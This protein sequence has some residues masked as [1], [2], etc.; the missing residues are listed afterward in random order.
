MKLQS[1][2]LQGFKS[3]AD[4]TVFDFEHQFTAVVGPNG[5]GKSNIADAIRWVLGEQSMKLLRSKSQVDL[6]FG[7]SKELSRLGMAQVTMHLDNSDKQFPVEYNEVVITRKLFR[8][9]ES[10]Y[11]LNNA[12]VRLQDITM[13]LAQ[14]QFGQKS[15]AV[16]GQGMIT[17]FLNATPQERKIFFDEATGVREFQMKRDQA[18]N[19]LIRS[20][21]NLIQSEAVL[22]E[23]APH[24]A[25]LQRQVDRLQK[26]EAIEKELHLLEKQYYGSSWNLF[27]QEKEELQKKYDIQRKEIHDIEGK[28]QVV[29]DKTDGIA[30]ETSR[31]QRYDMLQQES[32]VLL[33]KKSL[34]LKEQAL[35][36]AKLEI[37]QKKQGDLSLLWIEKKIDEIEQDVQKSH[38]AIEQLQ[39]RL[40]TS[41]TEKERFYSEHEALLS[42]IQEQEKQRQKVREQIEKEM[43]SMTL[44]EVEK[45]I[46]TI[47]YEQEKFLQEL[48]QTESLPAFRALQQEGKKLFKKFALFMDRFSSHNTGPADVLVL[49]SERIQEVITQMM[50]E[51]TRLKEEMNR[52]H[53]DSAMIEKEITLH[54]TQLTRFD[55]ERETLEKEK[56]AALSDRDDTP[57]EKEQAI[58]KELEE[59]QNRILAVDEENKKIRI[60][61]DD[62]HAAEEKKKTE[63]LN[64]QSQM[65][66][67]QRHL[68]TT[69]Q[70]A[71]SIEIQIARVDT[72]LQDMRALIERDVSETLHSAIFSSTETI[73]REELMKVEKQMFS[74]RKQLEAIGTIDA[75]IVT[76]Y[77]ETKERHDFLE[78]QVN[79][80]QK[81][82]HTLGEMIDD[83]DET[84]RLQFSR[85][86]KKINEGFEKYF[87]VLFHG[88]SAT[89]RMRTDE[90]DAESDEEKEE[91]DDAQM[92]SQGEQK[93]RELIG[94]KKK[95]Q[96]VISG[97]EVY[98]SPPQ[99][100]VT[101][102]QSLSGGEKSLV[103][104]A[105][106]CSI[107]ANNPAPFVV[108]DE[109]EAALDEEN[110]EKLAAILQS[111]S[112]QTQLIVVT[113]NR[114]TMRAADVLYGVTVSKEGKSHI[115]SVK[116]EDAQKMVSE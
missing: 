101:H 33:E 70:E 16:I 50:G 42:D 8:S 67:L 104:I 34:L 89:L 13:M 41:Q 83:L 23:I 90:A 18:V 97:I 55:Q 27:S 43:H 5:S 47:F 44:P 64:L 38:A 53:I 52:A 95:K 79:D 57:K 105:L 54:T 100:K 29:Q 93:A 63:L 84:I 116:L 14:A 99:K 60:D 2:S 6:I 4:K 66:S 10:E 7:G 46:A 17:D 9:G 91:N 72:R 3:F 26:R 112:K 61:L 109:V 35:L 114:V 106:L 21:E 37:E 82:I 19:K 51:V 75:S 103:A 59:Y 1:V 30:A 102:I 32:H 68:A 24:L 77:E 73:S 113:H 65:R 45:E 86:F 71:N 92:V 25:S 28:V 108:L 88:G 98:A 87:Q 36:K 76:E 74:A 69:Q 11:L 58:R 22:L 110:S 15:Y 111:L 48:L 31:T 78:E 80:L 62:F 40:S 49:E 39:K 107:I 12:P 85:N 96:K 56:A 20:E 81:T 115:L 94:K